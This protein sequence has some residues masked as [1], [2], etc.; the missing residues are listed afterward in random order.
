[1]P[2]QFLQAQLSCLELEQFYESCPYQ[3]TGI[4]PAVVYWSMEKGEA[5]NLNKIVCMHLMLTVDAM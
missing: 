2:P 3:G 1:M 4:Y 5:K